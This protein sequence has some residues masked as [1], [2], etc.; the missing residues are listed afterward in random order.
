MIKPIRSA[1]WAG[2]RAGRCGAYH[3]ANPFKTWTELLLAYAW[4]RGWEKAMRS[5]L[6]EWLVR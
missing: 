6:V 4:D 5:Q 3:T 1:Y 2:W